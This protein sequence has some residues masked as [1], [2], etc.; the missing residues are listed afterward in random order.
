M[1]PPAGRTDARLSMSG[2]SLCV[3]GGPWTSPLVGR[4]WHVNRRR[5]PDR[6][7]RQAGDGTNQAAQTGHCERDTHIGHIDHE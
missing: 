1:R 7:G 6:R 2:T 3:M 5:D 4:G